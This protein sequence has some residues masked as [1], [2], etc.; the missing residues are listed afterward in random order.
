MP[1]AFS[2]KEKEVI[3]QQMLEKS[4][5]LF[6][7]HG[8]RKTSVDD[9]TQA[10]G[11]SKGAFYLFYPS[12]EELFLEIMEQMETDLREGIFEYTLQPKENARENVRRILT[13]FLLTYD[14]YPL[15]KSFNQSDLDYLIRKLPAER[16]QAHINRDTKFFESFIKKIKREGIAIKVPP[17]VAMNLVLSLFLVSLH[18]QDFG[19]E[20][21]AENIK[22]LTDLVAGYLTG[23]AT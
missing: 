4:K 21:Y 20:A 7:L 3:R 17:R 10:A 2:E 9:I 8:L 1:K 13:N 23:G 16:M 6:E 11:I 5:R 22:I 19:E 18:R 15:L 14:A 12:K